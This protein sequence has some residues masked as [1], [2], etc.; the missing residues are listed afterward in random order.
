MGLRRYSSN[1]NCIWSKETVSLSWEDLLCINGAQRHPPAGGEG[2][3]GWARPCSSS[4]PAGRSPDPS[5]CSAQRILSLPTPQKGSL[6]ASC[7][8]PSYLHTPGMVDSPSLSPH[9]TTASGSVPGDC[10]GN[11]SI[12]LGCLSGVEVTG[13]TLQGTPLLSMWPARRFHSQMSLSTHKPMGAQRICKSVQLSNW[14]MRRVKK[15]NPTS[16][17]MSLWLKSPCTHPRGRAA[18]VHV[19]SAHAC[20]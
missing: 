15:K 6:V 1:W 12:T 10:G 7:P 13:C 16:P 18:R 2:V 5:C 14:R 8:T 3:S 9:H 17:R 19:L 11:C 20:R 4:H